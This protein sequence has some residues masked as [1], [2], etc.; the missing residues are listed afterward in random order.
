MSFKKSGG[1][2]QDEH[3]E[4]IRNPLA[5]GYLRK[6]AIGTQSVENLD[7]FIAVDDFRVE[8][9]ENGVWE[10]DLESMIKMAADGSEET[11]WPSAV[12]SEDHMRTVAAQI[13]DEFVSETSGSEVCI[14]QTERERVADMIKKL[15]HFG[16]KVFD[17]AMK[18]AIVSIKRQ[19]MPGFNLSKS[20]AQYMYVREILATPVD[21]DEYD[22]RPPATSM[23]D[24]PAFDGSTAFGPD[25][26]YTLQEI[27]SDH[28][29]IE[30]FMKFL[31]SQHSSEN[32]LCY[33]QLVEYDRTVAEN[34]AEE[35]AAYARRL[36]MSNS[37]AQRL[38][39]QSSRSSRAG[40]TAANMASS[41]QS[42]RTLTSS[43]AA[44]SDAFSLETDNDMILLEQAIKIYR[45]HLS[46]ESP[47]EVFIPGK[48]RKQVLKGMSE[49]KPE[50]YEQVKA[51]SYKAIQDSFKLFTAS[52]QYAG[53]VDLAADEY[54][55][56]AGKQAGGGIC[57]MLAG[58]GSGGGRTFERS[59]SRPSS[60]AASEASAE[61][62]N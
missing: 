23:I 39:Q 42:L 26:R 33:M 29:L 4:L 25:R 17:D 44:A 61:E 18:S 38:S 34:P 36:T 14:S 40:A 37:T 47:M 57:G 53:L 55:A 1:G 19:I 62:K 49:L 16:N 2:L 46:S 3:L 27:L 24:D 30:E 9:G 56:L 22:V 52:P 58:K 28:L 7:F 31:K 12:I 32:L 43:S 45:L 5:C 35:A 48:V 41:A 54:G 50:L 11:T 10:E 51:L 15:A 60:A 6:H 13:Y 59:T 8:F 20:H 21:K